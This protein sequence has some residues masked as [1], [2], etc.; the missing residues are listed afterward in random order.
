MNPILVNFRPSTIMNQADAENLFQLTAPMGYRFPN[1]CV[2]FDLIYAQPQKL[3]SSPMGAQ[4]MSKRFPPAL[5]ECIGSGNETLTIKLPPGEGLLTF[6]YNL[7]IE[8]QNAAEDA[9][10]NLWSFETHRRAVVD[11][12]YIIVDANRTVQG[13]SLEPL[14]GAAQEPGGAE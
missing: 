9:A 13:F 2:N 12:P 11:S 8:V 5:I 14:A 1:P 3:L 7:S 10:K 4:A 6:Y